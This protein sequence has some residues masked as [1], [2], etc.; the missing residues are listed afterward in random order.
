MNWM[1]VLYVA[2]GL[3]LLAAAVVIVMSLPDILRY[4]RISKM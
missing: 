1:I 3:A 4:I 2:G